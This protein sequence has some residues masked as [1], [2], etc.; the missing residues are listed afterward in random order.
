MRTVTSLHAVLL[1]GFCVL[2]MGMALVLTG[3]RSGL[4]SFAVALMAFGYLAVSHFSSR[5]ALARHAEQ[6]V[7]NGL[8][9]ARAA[10][11]PGLA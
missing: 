11:N 3:S 10:I 5:K 4:A 9:A 7:A 6:E 8:A 1:A 2:L